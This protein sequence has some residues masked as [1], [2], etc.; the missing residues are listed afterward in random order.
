MEDEVHYLDRGVNN[1]QALRH[2]GEGVAEEFVVQLD[3]DLL[4]ALSI[5]DAGCALTHAGVELIQG[6]SFFA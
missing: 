4:L 5:V 1:P 6:V 3:D 2:L